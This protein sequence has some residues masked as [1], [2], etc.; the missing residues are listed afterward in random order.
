MGKCGLGLFLFAGV[1]SAQGT[2]DFARDV[3]P[4]LR[5]RLPWTG[6]ATG[7]VAAGPEKF[8]AEG[9]FAAHCAGK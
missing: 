1:L 7:W 9:F 8:R 4:L 6:G 3:Q 5:Q 2:V